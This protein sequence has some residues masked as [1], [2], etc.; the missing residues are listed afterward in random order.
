LNEAEK[1]PISGKNEKLT[2][3]DRFKEFSGTFMPDRDD[4][5]LRR[6]YRDDTST[7][8]L[9]LSGCDISDKGIS[10]I[11]H[12][13]LDF[14]DVR[15]CPRVTDLCLPMI[16]EIKTL[17]HLRLD[18]FTHKT[19]KVESSF[20]PLAN[21]ARLRRLTVDGVRL[22]QKDF[23]ALAKIPNLESLHLNRMPDVTKENILAL[24][25][26]PRISEI[27]LGG[28]HHPVDI[29]SAL[30]QVK[31]LGTVGLTSSKVL[32]SEL[33]ALAQMKQV[34]NLMLQRTFVSDKG[35]MYLAKNMPNLKLL[36]VTACPNVTKK[37]KESFEKA[38]PEV[39]VVV[40]GDFGKV[41]SSSSRE[42]KSDESSKSGQESR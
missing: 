13:P 2:N 5:Y 22:S 33:S 17:E 25:K 12:L 14:L 23:E 32:D 42:T 3:D 20:T 1:P 15:F 31:T 19:T 11:K 16:G 27:V 41:E 4:E 18:N 35:M 21:L 7:R 37:G 6:T 9:E 38:W 26:M 39:H 8:R 10:Y 36:N 34:K 28:E 40:A 24:S 29:Y 30:A